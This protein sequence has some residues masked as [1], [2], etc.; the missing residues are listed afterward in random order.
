MRLEA[1]LKRLEAKAE[2]APVVIRVVWDDDADQEASAGR[3]IHLRWGNDR[4]P[5]RETPETP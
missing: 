1:R 2:R 5:L 4:A 3:V